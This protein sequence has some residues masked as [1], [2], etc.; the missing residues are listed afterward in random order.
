MVLVFTI[1]FNGVLSSFFIS[2][3]TQYLGALTI[4]NSLSSLDNYRDLD[5]NVI[6]QFGITENVGTTS[7]GAPIY[8]SEGYDTDSTGVNHVWIQFSSADDMLP[9]GVSLNDG[10]IGIYFG[11]YID[12][13]PFSFSG[14]IYLLSTIVSITTLES[15]SALASQITTGDLVN[16]IAYN[17]I[18][19]TGVFPYYSAGKG[20]S[21]V[22]IQFN[23]G[24]NVIVPP[25][26]TPISRP[27][28]APAD[29]CSTATIPSEDS[30]GYFCRDTSS[31][32]MCFEGPWLSSSVVQSCGAGTECR[33]ASGVECSDGNTVSPC[34]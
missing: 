23:I 33:C 26:S 30:I 13:L 1:F 22:K 3:G 20:V 11:Y 19:S 24:S 17:T 12:S 8:K 4:G 27:V 14:S 15:S 25:P 5:A 32:Y 2:N 16:P 34:S 10:S 21:Q 31:F 28:L 6:Y 29:F 18:S 7:S 9:Y